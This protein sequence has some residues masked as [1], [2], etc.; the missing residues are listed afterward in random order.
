[1]RTIRIYL[2]QALVVNQNVTIHGQ[3]FNHLIK[4]LRLKPNDTFVAFN[5]DG[6]DYKLVIHSIEKKQLS[7][8]V[9]SQ[10]TVLNESNLKITLYQAL[11]KSDHM[12]WTV[13]KSTELGVTTIVPFI[14]ERTQGRLND[15]Q[16]QKKQDHWQKII[17]SACEQSGRATLPKLSPL[18]HF[19]TLVNELVTN[20]ACYVLHFDKDSLYFKDLSINTN[21]I[22]IL[23]GAE[24]GF[25]DS[26]IKELKQQSVKILSLGSRVLRTETAAL[27]TISILQNTFGD[28]A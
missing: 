27:A 13:Q 7:A 20:Q 22:S 11:S 26:E 3:A 12:D 1:M 6:N 16:R 9:V 28:M 4:V 21:A 19:N 2:D 24:G 15:K 23:C 17:I 10:Q 5:G 25:S 8:E 14:S 18:I